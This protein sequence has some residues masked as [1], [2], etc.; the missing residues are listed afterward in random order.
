MAVLEAVARCDGAVVAA[1]ALIARALP[2]NA[3][4]VL[5]AARHAQLG[6][7]VGAL[8]SGGAHARAI[9]AAPAR[10]DASRVALLPL[11]LQ[12]LPSGVASALAAA[13]HSVDAAVARGHRAVL[14][15]PSLVTGACA[16]CADAVL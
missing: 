13:A 2:A 11:A 15:L 1:P 16:L 4:A 7:A 6:G 10:L 9:G 3:A 12:T 5:E 8:P 14:A